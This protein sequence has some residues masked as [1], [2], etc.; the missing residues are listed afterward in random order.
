MNNNRRKQIGKAIEKIE[1]VTSILQE[2]LNEEED[3][4]DNMPENLQGSVRGEQ[5]QEAIDILET[6][7]GNLEDI[8][9]EL[10]GI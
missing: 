10:T 4:F 5:S 9:D 8:V 7:I 1:E 3:A 2:V 6:S